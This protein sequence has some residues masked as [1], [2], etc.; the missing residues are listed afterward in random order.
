MPYHFSTETKK[1]IVS[2]DVVRGIAII[3]MVF[4]HGLH[5]FYTGRSNNVISLFDV[6]SLGDMA[7]PFFYTISGAALYLSI[8]SRLKAG[9]DFRPLFAF[10]S[11]RFCQLFLIGVMLSKAWGVLQAQAVSLFLVAVAFLTARKVL[12]QKKV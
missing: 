10:Y 7:T 4:S 11:K 1:R 6:N 8:L 3:T 2:I 9:K 5:W 12:D